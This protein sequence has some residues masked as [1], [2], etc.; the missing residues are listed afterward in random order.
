MENNKDVTKKYGLFTAITM[1][2]G[3]C[4][5]SGIFFKSDNVLIATDGNILL[6]VISFVLAAISIIFGCLTIGELAAHTD[7]VGGLISY[8]E[9]F[10]SRQIACAMGWFQTFI[11]YPTITSVVAWVIGVYINILFDLQASLGFE[12]IVG[13]IFLLMCFTYNIFIPKF[14]AFIQNS[15]TLI[16]LLPLFI[17]GVLGIIFGDPISG[18]SHVDSYTLVSTGWISALGP[19]AYSFDGWIVTTSISHELKNAKRN[20]PK[21]LML[22]PIIV[23]SIYILYFVGISC[24]IGPEAVMEL[25]DAH[26]SLAATKLFGPT[27]S[28]V[29]IIFIIISV[30]GTVNGLVIGY[31]RMPYSLAVR[32]NMFPFSKHISKINDRFQMPLNSAICSLLIC[33]FW[34]IIH[35]LCT[36]YDLLFNSDV[37]EGAIVIS[38][39]LYTLLYM[40]VIKMYLDKEIESKFKGI[41]CPI[42][43][44][45]GSIIILSAGIQNKLFIVYLFLAVVLFVYSLHYYKKKTCKE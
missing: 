21:A 36:Q 13:Y 16:K 14:G 37:S 23:L 34:M 6:G 9:M 5:G 32:K 19:I 43:A 3:I 33:T 35:Y 11:Y 1:I 10:L 12:I 31:I 40:R 38:Y 8:A 24:Y 25:G 30:I 22:G 39:I 20:M 15:T 2:I 29:I 28:K 41:V 4:I 44:T 42:L 18:L 26:V 45:I 27:F 17:F 7:K